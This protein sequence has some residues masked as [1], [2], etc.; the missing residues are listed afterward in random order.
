VKANNRTFTKPV[1][2]HLTVENGNIIRLHLYE[3]T[4]VVSQAIAG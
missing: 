3:D 2:F 1:A 4:H